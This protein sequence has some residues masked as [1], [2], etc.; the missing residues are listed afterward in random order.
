VQSNFQYVTSRGG[1][2]R[3]FGFVGFKTAQEAV[4]AV[5]N[6]NGTYIDT[7]KIQV[8]YSHPLGVQVEPTEKKPL[9]TTTSDLDYLKSK[10]TKNSVEE[11]GRIFINNLSYTTTEEE[12]S[13]LFGKY[14][15]IS[16]CHLSIDRETK[17]SKG[18]AFILYLIPECATKALELDKTVFQGRIIRVVPSEL[19]LV[20]KKEIEGLTYKQQLV[21][22][23]KVNSGKT[24]NW[25]SLFMKTDTVVD[26]ISKQMGVNKKDL[27]DRDSDHL[28]VRVALGEAELI[29]QTKE[30]LER[31]GIDFDERNARS[32][33]MIL[34]KNLPKGV[35]EG[36]LEE[37][38]KTYGSL[39]KII[40]PSS[41]TI[42]LVE[43]SEHNEAK[44]AFR[45]LSYKMF[46][47]T[48]LYLEWAPVV[49]KKKVDE[50]VTIKETVEPETN[51]SGVLFVKNLNF[52]T[53]KE[54]LEEV[55]EQY[56]NL[57]KVTMLTGYGFV[58]FDNLKDAVHA[59]DGLKDHV[60][61][62]HKI[63][64]Q[65]S[66]IDKKDNVK[67]D[68]GQKKLIVKNLPFEA[69]KKDLYDLFSPFGKIK[70]VRIP[71]KVGGGHRG[72]GFIEF[73]SE[74]DSKNALASLKNAHLYGRHLVLEYASK[75]GV[76]VQK[77]KREDE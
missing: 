77:R 17:Q 70:V 24:T 34:V 73:L 8:S 62:N 66:H 51:E 21:E 43:F 19:P 45:G 20:K 5:N 7:A 58:E 14:G 29:K 36:D 49:R 68:E 4:D 57:R 11:T 1:K 42:G 22:K 46:K 9:V 52:T 27:L 44:S 39:R 69:T 72:F 13:D 2:T 6:V 74:T 54:T 35:E 37:L 53:T 15:D 60:I 71:E 76:E 28:A 47:H 75:D 10:K 3:K 18:I 25:N 16:E 55:F 12:L 56:G 41:K 30:D 26:T 31:E 33:T 61:D 50:V 40:I 64:I 59:H 48:P 65:Y 23:K 67:Q 63:V 38:F 32:K